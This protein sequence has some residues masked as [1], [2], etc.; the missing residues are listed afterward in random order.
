M[1]ADG[2]EARQRCACGARDPADWDL[3]AATTGTMHTRWA[4]WNR[5]ASYRAVGADTDTGP[6]AARR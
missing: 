3:T 1:A 2:T 6:P 5:G 4:C